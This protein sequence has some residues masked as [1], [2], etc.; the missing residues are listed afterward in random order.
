MGSVDV[1]QSLIRPMTVGDVPHVVAIE[2]RAFTTPWRFDTFRSLLARD[3]VEL[4]VVELPEEGVVAYAV[5]WCTGDHGELANIA[6]R[7][8]ARGRGLGSALLN[9]V[10]DVARQRGVESLFLEVRVSNERAAGM[11]RRRGFSE[12]GRRKGYYDR[13]KEDALVLVKRLT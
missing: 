5:L 10:L 3:E 8:D 6:V 4:T 1:R 7:D 2:E 9:R 11:Y 13:P 12:I